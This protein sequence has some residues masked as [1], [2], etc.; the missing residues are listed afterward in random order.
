MPGCTGNAHHSGLLP[1]VRTQTYTTAAHIRRAHPAPPVPLGI[2]TLRL[3]CVVCCV[4]CAL[5]DSCLCEKCA[6]RLAEREKEAG[7]DP[8][9]PKCRAVI[10]TIHKTF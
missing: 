7:K 8:Q 10:R 1:S 5:L 6:K 3:L 9:C 2:L 4:V